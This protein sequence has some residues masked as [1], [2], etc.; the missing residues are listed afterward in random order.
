MVKERELLGMVAP[1]K[2]EIPFE[3]S[4]HPISSFNDLNSAVHYPKVSNFFTAAILLR[5]EMYNKYIY[6]TVE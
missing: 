4:G 5:N 6:S 2:I 1:P 3:Y